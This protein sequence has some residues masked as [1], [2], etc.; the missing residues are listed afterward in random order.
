MDALNEWALKNLGAWVVDYA[1]LFLIIAVALAVILI[2]TFIIVACCH[3]KNKKRINALRVQN[4]RLASES[5]GEADNGELRAQVRAEI[6]PIIREQVEREYAANA[7]AAQDGSAAQRI[8]ELEDENLEKQNRINALSAALEQSNSANKSNDSDLYRTIN[9]LN[10]TNKELENEINKLKAENAQMKAQSLQKQLDEATRAASANTSSANNSATTR[11]TPTRTAPTRPAAQ[12]QSAEP[13]RTVVKKKPVVETPPD[14]DDDDDEYYDDY[15][16][17][18]SAVKVTLKFDRVK[19]NWV[20]LRTDTDRAYRRLA[21]KQEALVVA[22]DLAR[23]L[24]AQLVVHKKDGK[25][26]KI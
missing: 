19:N 5:G 3:A 9:E 25:F 1:T 2:L 23:R 15:G 20:I 21:T 14:D 13:Q 7:A 18:T 8:A 11:P 22:K 12:T 6:E 26:Q 16:D 10:Q 17:E 4:K 24:H